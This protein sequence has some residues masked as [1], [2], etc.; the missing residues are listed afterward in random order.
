MELPA[1]LPPGRLLPGCRAAWQP[2]SLHMW[3][4]STIC[5]SYSHFVMKKEKKCFCCLAAWGK[6]HGET[7]LDPRYFPLGTP[8]QTMESEQK[9][10]DIFPDLRGC[11]TTARHP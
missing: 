4:I 3:H 5:H 1:P 9:K 7:T 11:L 8:P 2:S 10:A 6:R